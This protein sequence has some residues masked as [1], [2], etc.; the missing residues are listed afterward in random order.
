MF[1]VTEDELRRRYDFGR[2]DGL[3]EAAVAE[4][5]A[6]DGRALLRFLGRYISWNGGFGA[7]VANLAG[8]I[9]RSKTLFLDED[10][11][12]P[13]CADRSVHVASYFFDAARDEFDDGATKHRDTHRTLAQAVLKGVIGYYDIGI[14]E[15]IGIL[16]AP[17]WLEGLEARTQ[18]GYGYGTPDTLPAMFRSMGFHLGSEVLADAE[19]S[20]IDTSL[21]RRCPELVENLL[22]TKVRIADQDHPAYYWVGIHSGHGGGVEEE[23]FEWAV[24]GVKQGFRFVP[25]RHHAYLRS[26]VLAGFDRFAACHQEFFEHVST[27]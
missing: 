4:A 9:A 7:G 2:S 22:H 10:E 11:P 18:S 15:A 16:E 20:R 3:V 6:G 12:I 25:A 24:T 21:R 5:T 14:D 26:Q 27:N 17:L 19:F 13:A 8:K 23:H 1:D